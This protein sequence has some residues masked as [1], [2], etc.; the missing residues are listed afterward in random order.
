MSKSFITTI[1]IEKSHKCNS[2]RVEFMQTLPL[3]YRSKKM[4]FLKDSELNYNKSKISMNKIMKVKKNKYE[5]NNVSGL[6]YNVS[7][8]L[9]NVFELH[10]SVSNLC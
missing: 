10:I 4:L 8:I 1:Y 6:C 7:E 3:L 9:F 5:Q 2:G